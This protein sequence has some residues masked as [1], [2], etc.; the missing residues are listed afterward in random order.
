MQSVAYVSRLSSSLFRFL[1][2]V[3]SAY[4]FRSTLL[5]DFLTVDEVLYK[6]L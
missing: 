4:A 2:W 6:R 1:P 5:P 3:G